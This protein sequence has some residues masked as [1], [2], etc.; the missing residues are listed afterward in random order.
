MTAEPDYELSAKDH[1]IRRAVADSQGVGGWAEFD[2]I[3]DGLRDEPL[4][5]GA[6]RQRLD[7]M[8]RHGY[9]IRDGNR[10]QLGDR[11]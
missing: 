11:R 10:W 7:G 3:R 4:S 8:A 9:L 1:L 6:V 2:Q 5:P